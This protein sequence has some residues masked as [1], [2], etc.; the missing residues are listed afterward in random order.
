MFGVFKNQGTTAQNLGYTSYSMLVSQSG[1]SAPT[2]IDLS[3]NC[4]GISFSYL[5]VGYFMCTGTGLF[6]LNKTQIIFGDVY[7]ISI[8]GSNNIVVD[9]A[10]LGLNSFEFNTF[11]GSGTTANSIL[12]NTTLEIRVYP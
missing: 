10:E 12:A 2:R 9:S 1:T 4:S 3:G 5:G 8:T 6:T 7:N 11:D